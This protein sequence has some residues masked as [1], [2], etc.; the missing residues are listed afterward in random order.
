LDIIYEVGKKC[1][2][3]EKMAWQEIYE[4]NHLGEIQLAQSVE[5][6]AQELRVGNKFR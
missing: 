2:F 6:M 4:F 1:L 5:E 3:F